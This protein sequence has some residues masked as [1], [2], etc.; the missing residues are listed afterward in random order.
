MRYPSSRSRLAGVLPQPPSP[1]PC[2]S[3]RPGP[4]V[5]TPTIM[6]TEVVHNEYGYPYVRNPVVLPPQAYGEPVYFSTP[7]AVSYAPRT[8]YRTIYPLA[9]PTYVAPPAPVYRVP[10]ARVYYVP[11]PGYYYMP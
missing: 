2:R 6:R 1:R 5:R 11:K 3:P 10:P 4:P 9:E 8:Y 7:G